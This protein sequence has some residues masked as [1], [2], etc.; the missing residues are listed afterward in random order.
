MTYGD[1]WTVAEAA[2]MFKIRERTLR[3]W[4]RQERLTVLTRERGPDL[5]RGADVVELLRIRDT[6]GRMPRPPKRS[7][8]ET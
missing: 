2:V 3:R 8:T 4:I 1:L 6:H 7:V 5:V